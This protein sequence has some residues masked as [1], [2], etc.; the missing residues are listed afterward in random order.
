MLAVILAEAFAP[1]AE[2]TYRITLAKINGTL[3]MVIPRAYYHMYPY[4][5]FADYGKPKLLQSTD[6][7]LSQEAPKQSFGDI[8]RLFEHNLAIYLHCDQSM[9]KPAVSLESH[10]LPRA[11]SSRKTRKGPVNRPRS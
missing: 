1:L 4:I 6:S 5:S 7:F 9:R 10:H 8:R 2:F 3:S 11:A